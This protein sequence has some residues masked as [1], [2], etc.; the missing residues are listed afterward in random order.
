MSR[1][2]RIKFDLGETQGREWQYEDDAQDNQDY[3][4]DYTQDYNQDNQDNQD[5]DSEYDS[6]EEM[7]SEDDE[8]SEVNKPEVYVEEP[9]P[10]QPLT[11]EEVAVLKSL[12]EAKRQA[13]QQPTET[14]MEAAYNDFI[15]QVEAEKKEKEDSMIREISIWVSNGNQVKGDTL[16]E[17]YTYMTEQKIVQEKERKEQEEKERQKQAKKAEQALIAA[18][19]RRSFWDM[20]TTRKQKAGKTR[21]AHTNG[22]VSYTHLTLPTKRIV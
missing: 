3:N 15:A 12:E 8:V 18:Q 16:E 4:Q 5:Q 19:N 10:E 13:K 7:Y 9:Q 21:P 20:E 1:I 14:D 2:N 22:P 6:W 11:E 17:H